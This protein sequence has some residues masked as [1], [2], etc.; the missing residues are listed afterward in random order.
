[1]HKFTATTS[2]CVRYRSKNHH[3]FYFLKL[4]FELGLM[5]YFLVFLIPTNGF[6]APFSFNVVC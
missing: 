5:I 4:D 6:L 3:L 1:M 2:L